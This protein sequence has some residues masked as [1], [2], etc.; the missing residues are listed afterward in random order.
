M[1]KTFKVEGMHCR[2]CEKLLIDVLSEIKGLIKA[3]ADFRKGTVKISIS[4]QSAIEGAR[5]A[6]IKEGYGVVG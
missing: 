2:S 3:E 4:D 1:E 5:D 6:I